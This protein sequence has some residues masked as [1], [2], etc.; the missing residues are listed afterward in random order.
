MIPILNQVKLVF[1][2]IFRFISVLLEGFAYCGQTN[3]ILTK[4]H[5]SPNGEVNIRAKKLHQTIKQAS[6]L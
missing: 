3:R 5:H 6:Q 1:K 4:P 2:H